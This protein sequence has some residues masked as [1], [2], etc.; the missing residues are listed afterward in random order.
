[1]RHYR[2]GNT[3]LAALYAIAILETW[4]LLPWLLTWMAGFIHRAPIA[5]P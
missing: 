3:I 5:M 4:T 2:A 1:M